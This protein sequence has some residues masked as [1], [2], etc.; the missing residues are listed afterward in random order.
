MKN[1]TLP[2]QEETLSLYNPL[3]DDFSYMWFDDENKGHL[4]TLPSMQ[5]TVLPTSQG[6]FMLQ[7]LT[8][9]IDFLRGGNLRIDLRRE[10][11]EKEILK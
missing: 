7:H 1:P 2:P 10:A 8:D 3:K 9:K 5:I 4:L 11:I 6:R